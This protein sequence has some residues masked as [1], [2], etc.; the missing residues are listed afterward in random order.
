M[1]HELKEEVRLICS[2]ADRAGEVIDCEDVGRAAKMEMAKYLMYLSASDGEIKYSE[3]QVI[4]DVLDI[5]LNPQQINDFI[6][7]NNVYSVDFENTVPSVFGLLVEMDNAIYNNG[8]YDGTSGS[9]LMLNL[10]KKL[11]VEL[12][13][14]DGNSDDNE[15]SDFVI[16]ITMLDNHLNEKLLARNAGVKVGFSKTGST[17]AP[18]KSGVSAPKKG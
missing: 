7:E 17:K 10:Y 14:T 3:A 4:S 11:G 15:K 2:L 13:E 12:I 5:E 18:A 1:N 6:R 9:E 16:F 8:G